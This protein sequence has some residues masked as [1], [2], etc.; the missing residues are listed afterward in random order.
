MRF[1]KTQTIG[2]DFVLLHGADVLAEG[3]ESHLPQIAI[4]LCER[5]FGIGSDGLLV[6]QPDD[7]VLHLRMFNPDGTEDFCGNGLRCAALHANRQSWV[8]AEHKIEH[9]G[10]IV[11]AIVLPDG[12]V[13]TAI[14]P[15]V[16]DPEEVPLDINTH[17]GPMIDE[18]V[19][20]Y[21]GSAINAGTTHF[22]AFVTEL[23]GDDELNRIGPLIEHAPVF[24]ERTSVIFAQEVGDRRVKVRIWERGAGETLGCGTGSSATAAEWMRRHGAA[25]SVEVFNPGGTLVVTADEIG[26]S[27]VTQSSPVEAYTGTFELRVA[28][29]V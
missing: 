8:E 24:P 12:S 29:R 15:A 17:P 21:R 11:S 27:L 26:G 13:K 1:W 2:N 6:V 14:G 28:Q 23:P 16:Y 22:V 4:D 20:G 3:L 10:R 25:G 5:R 18:E 7:G 19:L 9:F